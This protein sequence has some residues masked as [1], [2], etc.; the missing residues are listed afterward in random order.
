MSL[1]WRDEIGVCLT[2]SRL[3]L[4]RMRRGLRAQCVR[5]LSHPLPAPAGTDWR[6]AV[7]MLAGLLV[8]PEWAGAGLRVAVA[9]QWV[10]QAVVPAVQGIERES[11]QLL[12]ARH[13]LGQTYGDLGEDWQVA[14]GEGLPGRPFV[15]AA[16]PVA[17]VASLRE[18][19]A[20][21][22]VPL[23]SVAPQLAVTYERW[24][25]HLPTSGWLVSIHDDYLAAARLAVHGWDRIHAVRCGTDVPAELR[26]LGVLDRLASGDEATPRLLVDASPPI[27]QEWQ[28]TII[29]GVEWLED[30]RMP[31]QALTAATHARGALA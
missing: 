10:R 30:A 15:A 23:L 11:E 28:G 26:R 8:E 19:A 1:P 4:V 2:P 25:S 24:R 20:G 14:I 13:W 29:E 5:E 27:R 31:R 22:G 9:D 6:S 7:A 18:S 3:V 12:Y 16:L 21:A 17:L